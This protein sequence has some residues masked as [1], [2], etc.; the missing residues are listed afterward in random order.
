MLCMAVA[1]RRAERRSQCVGHRVETQPQST[2]ASVSPLGSLAQPSPYASLQ[3][4]L[5][6]VDSCP[7]GAGTGH[8]K[9]PSVTGWGL[10]L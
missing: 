8:R 3:L 4:A 7:L 1:V 2:E 6:G 10:F 9:L 5:T